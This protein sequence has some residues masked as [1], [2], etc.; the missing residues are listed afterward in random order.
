MLKVGKCPVILK[1][2]SFLSFLLVT[3]SLLPIFINIF[4]L[5]KFCVFKNII[6]MI[7]QTMFLLCYCLFWLNTFKVNLIETCTNSSLLIT[8][9]HYTVL[10]T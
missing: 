1:T 10:C 6:Y 5:S 7:Q 3:S 8:V 4:S 2:D 9:E